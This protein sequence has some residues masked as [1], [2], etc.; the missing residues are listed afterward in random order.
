MRHESKMDFKPAPE[1]RMTSSPVFKKKI[2][3]INL[4]PKSEKNNDRKQDDALRV[5]HV[6]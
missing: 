2:M 3:A 6:P 1:L 4:H 5:S